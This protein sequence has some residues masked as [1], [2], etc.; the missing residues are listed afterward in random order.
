M[1]LLEQQHPQKPHF[2]SFQMPWT[3]F[4]NTLV[5]LVMVKYA[6]VAWQVFHF[7]E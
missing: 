3:M 1:Y 7:I 2:Y 5:V 4:N 6:I